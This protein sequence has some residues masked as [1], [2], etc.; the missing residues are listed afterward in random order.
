MYQ[1]NGLKIDCLDVFFFFFLTA[2]ETRSMV[3]DE[4]SIAVFHKSQS[5]SFIISSHVNKIL[6]IFSST[7]S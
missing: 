3:T 1:A 2:E 5:V 6:L 4:E 7:T